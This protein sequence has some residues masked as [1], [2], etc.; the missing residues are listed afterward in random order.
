MGFLWTQKDEKYLEYEREGKQTMYQGHCVSKPEFH[1][2]C[3]DASE[4]QTQ[5]NIS[6]CVPVQMASFIN[7]MASFSFLYT[8]ASVSVFIFA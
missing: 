7:I 8:A 2:C 1:Q 6:V 4:R 3:L 5:A